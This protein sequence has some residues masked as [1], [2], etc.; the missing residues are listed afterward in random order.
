MDNPPA[1]GDYVDLYFLGDNGRRLAVD[2]RENAPRQRWDFEVATNMAGAEVQI[3]LPDLSEVPHDRVVYL[4]DEAA[5][6]RIYARTQ[7]SYSYDAGEGGTRRFRLEVVERT[8]AGLTISAASAQSHDGGATVSYTLSTD[9]HVRV[10][11]LNIAGRTI[12]VLASDEAKTAG[13]ASATWSGRSRS[14]TLVPG[15]RYLVRI[16]ARAEDGQQTQ[17]LVPLNF[18]R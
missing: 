10:E 14:G 11:V 8:E 12:A 1:L 15:G 4:Y 3:Q 17:A 13:V 2:V 6:K 9:A 16:T 7:P 5:D 18:E